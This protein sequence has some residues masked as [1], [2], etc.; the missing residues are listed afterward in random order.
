MGK[1]AEKADEQEGAAVMAKNRI[2]ISILGSDYIIASEEEENYVRQIAAETEKRI[3]GIT[4]D[5]PR[6]SVTMAAVLAA[7]DYCDEA[8]KA[9]ESADNLRSQIKDYLE[10]SSQAR[11]EADEARRENEKLKKEVQTLRSRL[12]H[13]AAEPKKSAQVPGR[14]VAARRPSPGLPGRTALTASRRRSR[15]RKA[16]WIRKSWS[17]SSQARRRN[18]S[19]REAG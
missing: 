5:N 7:L 15:R 6:L 16:R 2:K 9:T 12:E 17:F 3:A 18:S 8:V 10:D 19:L 11:M 1:V 4:R 13:Q 14:T